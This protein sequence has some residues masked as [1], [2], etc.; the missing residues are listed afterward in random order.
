MS[1]MDVLRR[2]NHTCFEF[3]TCEKIQLLSLFEN[4]IER[5]DKAKV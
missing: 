3:V 2:G 1:T 5:E 4:N